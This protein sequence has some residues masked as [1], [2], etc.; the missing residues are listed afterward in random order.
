[1]SIP[2]QLTEDMKTAMKAGEADRLGTVRLL[3]GAMKNEEI[4]LGHP[5]TDDEALKVLQREG[6]QRR[7]SIEQYT[8]AGR[9]ELAAKEAA[10][11]AIVATYLPEPLSEVQLS[12]MID[13]AIAAQ[14]ATDMKQMG[15][16]TGAV[17]SQVGARAEGGLVSRL[18]REKLGSS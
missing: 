2:E 14:G 12:A 10:E 16:V 7:D 17:M 13:E 4:K 5:L 15:A 3:R 8:S 6:K 1:M 9:S 18:V 11:L